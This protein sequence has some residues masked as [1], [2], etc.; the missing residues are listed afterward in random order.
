[1]AVHW[2]NKALC[3]ESFSGSQKNFE[4]SKNNSPYLFHTQ[5]PT[6]LGRHFALGLLFPKIKVEMTAMNSNFWED[7]EGLI[8]F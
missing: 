1:L 7:W 4:S 8:R 6:H 2:I 3:I 5:M